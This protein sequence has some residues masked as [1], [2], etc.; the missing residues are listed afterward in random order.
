MLPD[1]AF[2]IF[3]HINF[4]NEANLANPTPSDVTAKGQVS[5]G[6]LFPPA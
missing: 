6:R 1:S 2:G 5:S 3:G 4:M